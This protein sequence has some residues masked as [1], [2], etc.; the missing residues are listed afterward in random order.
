VKRAL[1]AAAA[2][3][4]EKEANAPEE[5]LMMSSADFATGGTLFSAKLYERR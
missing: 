5:S 2:L 3:G 4:I 1:E